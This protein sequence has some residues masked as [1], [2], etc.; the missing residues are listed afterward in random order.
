MQAG[1]AARQWVHLDKKNPVSLFT[2][3]FEYP[4]KDNAVGRAVKFVTNLVGPKSFR[5]DLQ[6]VQASFSGAFG[7]RAL[8]CLQVF[9]GPLCAPD[10]L[11]VQAE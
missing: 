11:G 10:L 8:L 3:L 5:Q 2:G 4:V 1:F 9:E 6:F 7:V